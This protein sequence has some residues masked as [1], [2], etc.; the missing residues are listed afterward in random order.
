MVPTGNGQGYWLVGRDGGVFTFGNARFVGSLPGEGIA[1]TVTSVA[2]T[3]DGGGYLLSGA[4][5]RVYSFGDAPFFGDPASAVPGWNSLAL[6]VFA[7][8]G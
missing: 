7:K 1:D 3:A 8:R 2:A 5:G 4:G 6:G